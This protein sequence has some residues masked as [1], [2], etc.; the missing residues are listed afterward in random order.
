MND[1]EEITSTA[2]AIWAIISCESHLPKD[3]RNHYSWTGLD[4][5]IGFDVDEFTP[6]SERLPGFRMDD[7]SKI[8]MGYF[9]LGHNKPTI[10]QKIAFGKWARAIWEP[11]VEA[12]AWLKGRPHVTG[13]YGL[14]DLLFR[15]IKESR[16]NYAS[17]KLEMPAC[18]NVCGVC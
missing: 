5:D 9:A 7:Y 11:S 10:V 12:L 14:H 16:A 2:G 13:P 8:H 1:E 18:F 17:K 4:P 3:K 15:T 6:K